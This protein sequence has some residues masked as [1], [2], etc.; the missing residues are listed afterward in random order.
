MDRKYQAVSLDEVVRQLDHLNPS[1]EKG[2]LKAVFEKSK[3]VFD[4]MLGTYSKTKINTIE[5]MSSD[6]IH[7]KFEEES[8]T[9]ILNKIIAGGSVFTKI[10]E[11]KYGCYKLHSAPKTAVSTACQAVGN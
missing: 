4:G 6:S 3:R 7:Y 5:L 9:R 11:S 10:G 1:T 2:Q 8:I